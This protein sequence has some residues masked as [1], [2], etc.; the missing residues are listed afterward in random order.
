ML[1]VILAAS[2]SWAQSF[3]SPARL[4]LSKPYLVVIT[5]S[6]YFKEDYDMTLEKEKK[7]RETDTLLIIVIPSMDSVVLYS[8]SSNGFRERCSYMRY[9]TQY[10]E[11]APNSYTPNSAANK[12][13]VVKYGIRGYD[14]VNKMDIDKDMGGY[15]IYSS[16][17][18]TDKSLA[19]PFMKEKLQKAAVN[20]DLTKLTLVQFTLDLFTYFGYAVNLPEA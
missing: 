10:S 19:L 12:F 6:C 20:I 5:H 16:N 11:N 1:V 4:D 15:E 7:Y 18:K 2:H 9:N 8:K 17:A 14:A 13:I 3:K